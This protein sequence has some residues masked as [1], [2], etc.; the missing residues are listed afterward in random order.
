MHRIKPLRARGGD[1]DI[2]DADNVTSLHTGT[3]EEYSSHVLA[4]YD[5]LPQI[6]KPKYS[7]YLCFEN[8]T[9]VYF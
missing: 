9:A 8:L 3:S 6:W 4:Q 1:Q 7:V 5:K 2:S